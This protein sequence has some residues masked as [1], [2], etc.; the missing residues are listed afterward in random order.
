MSNPA[1]TPTPTSKAI[2]RLLKV[3]VR[4]MAED[5]RH[6]VTELMV[7]AHYGADAMHKAEQWVCGH[8]PKAVVASLRVEE[9]D[10]GL[11]IS[12][13]VRGWQV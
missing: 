7:A 12:Q 10:G 3:H 9:V 5:G 1:P 13:S 8:S 11:V 4:F 6:Q 2:A